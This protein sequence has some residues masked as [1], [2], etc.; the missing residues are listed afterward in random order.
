MSRSRNDV[1]HLYRHFGLDPSNYIDV[2][3]RSSKPDS[4]SAH[5]LSRTGDRMRKDYGDRDL[6]DYRNFDLAS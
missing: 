2:S 3:G 1:Q 5:S 4:I 6:Y